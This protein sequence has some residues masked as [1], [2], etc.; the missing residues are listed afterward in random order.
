MLV[1]DITVLLLFPLPILLSVKKKPHSA[2]HRKFLITEYGFWQELLS[3]Q[4]SQACMSLP[5]KQC[6]LLIESF[7]NIT[8]LS[9]IF[10]NGL[11]LSNFPAPLFTQQVHWEETGNLHKV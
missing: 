6:K 3:K 1:Q 9:V 10:F 4:F 8:G 11:S 2:G 5:K 7:C